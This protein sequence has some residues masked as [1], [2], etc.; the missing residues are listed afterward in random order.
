MPRSSL[1]VASR[2]FFAAILALCITL[3]AFA[4][5]APAPLRVMSFNVRVPVD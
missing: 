1:R 5:S 3:P 4:A 2:C